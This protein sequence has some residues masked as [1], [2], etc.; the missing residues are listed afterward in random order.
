M[1]R[2]FPDQD[3]TPRKPASNDDLWRY[4]DFTQFVSILENEALWFSQAASFFDPYE[5]ALPPAKLEEIAQ[6][7]P[8]EVDEPRKLV[9]RM[10]D[11]LRRSTYVNCWHQRSDES[12]AMWQVYQD[13]GK[14][15]AVRT[16]MADFE[17]AFV[18]KPGMTCGYVKYMDYSMPENFA[19]DRIAPF[20]YKRPGFKHE[21]EFRAVISEF[22]PP[23]GAAVDDGFAARVDD[24]AAEGKSV[25][26]NP[27]T[28]IKEVVVS[29]VAGGWLESLVDNV[30]CSY[31]LGDVPVHPSE[32]K[33]EPFDTE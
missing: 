22:K 10:Y 12:A 16:T 3:W 15:V 8:D 19:E 26:V 11:A 7:I 13:K 5:G 32:L 17:D 29:P 27:E 24:E 18:E 1:D 14:E 33:D 20:F 25:G 31:G 4:I 6:S 21:E 28:L 9:A 2:L 23:E 30:L